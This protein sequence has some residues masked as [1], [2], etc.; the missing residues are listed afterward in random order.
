MLVKLRPILVTLERLESFTLSSKARWPDSASATASLASPVRFLL[1]A[2]VAARL[3]YLSIDW[4]NVGAVEWP[5]MPRLVEVVDHG[6]ARDD[7]VDPAIGEATGGVVSAAFG[8]AAPAVTSV[9]MHSGWARLR[10]VG[11]DWIGQLRRVVL[12]DDGGRD[13]A[14]H[15]L[16]AML[17]RMSSLRWLVLLDI[18][19]DRAMAVAMPVSLGELRVVLSQERT[20]ADCRGVGGAL[21]ELVARTDMVAIQRLLVDCA[22]ATDELGQ[23]CTARNITLD[24]V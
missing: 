16:S 23:A 13:Q 21:L 18:V 8:E 5:A 7:E 10:T 9:S 1:D 14:Q 3:K 6:V 2:P 15:D 12:G 17:A 24:T 20:K 22:A 19:F 4:P 11:D